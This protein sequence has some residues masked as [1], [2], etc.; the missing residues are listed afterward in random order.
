MSYRARTFIVWLCII[1]LQM[2]WVAPAVSAVVFQAG[3]AA[4]T[5][6]YICSVGEHAELKQPTSSSS[7]SAPESGVSIDHSCCDMMCS[8]HFSAAPPP[9]AFSFEPH[10]IGLMVQLT[11]NLERYGLS[12]NWNAAESRAPPRHLQ[13]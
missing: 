7:D 8:S 4:F 3:S 11:L 2:G 13:A 6:G 1:C 9:K 5:G 10:T 12:K